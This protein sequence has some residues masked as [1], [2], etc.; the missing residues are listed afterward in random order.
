MWVSALGIV[1]VSLARPFDVWDVLL[2]LFA[3][4]VFLVAA[5]V[6]GAGGYVLLRAVRSAWLLDGTW[7]GERRVTRTVW[8]DLASAEVDTEYDERSRHQRVVVR[9]PGDGVVIRHTVSDD[10][11]LLGTLSAEDLVELADAITRNRVRADGEDRALVIAD[12]LRRLAEDPATDVHVPEPGSGGESPAASEDVDQQADFS[13]EVRTSRDAWLRGLQGAAVL[14]PLLGGLVVAGFL[15][16]FA[17]QAVT[18]AVG[19]ALLAVVKFRRALKDLRREQARRGRAG[20][21]TAG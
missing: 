15:F 17:R 9:S 14:G 4:L 16:G 5:L 7:L 21:P 6:C 19:I 12:R 1:D 2:G 11:G 13:R 18:V 3:V 8:V 10:H 20:G